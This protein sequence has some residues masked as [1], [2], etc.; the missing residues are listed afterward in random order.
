MTIEKMKELARDK[1]VCV[2]ATASEGTP[3]CSL[4]AY[5][6]DDGCNEVYMATFKN[7]KK[8]K[9]LMEN[10]NVSLLVDTREEHDGPLRPEAKAMTVDGTF[11]QIQDEKKKNWIRAKL[12]ERHPYLEEFLAH[13]DAE[14]FCIKIRSFLLLD[15]LTDAHFEK[16]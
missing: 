3:H 5:V 15:G 11:Q 7:T 2:L 8:F 16:I 6:V 10:P 1:D 4:M 12:L 13:P 9:N 14:V